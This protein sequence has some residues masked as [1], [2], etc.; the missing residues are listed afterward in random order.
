MGARDD[1]ALS[2]SLR[3][4]AASYAGAFALHYIWTIVPVQRGCKFALGPTH[5]TRVLPT[6]AEGA[7]LDLQNREASPLVCVE[8]SSPLDLHQSIAQSIPDIYTVPTCI[9]KGTPMTEILV[10]F[11]VVCVIEYEIEGQ[12]TGHADWKWRACASVLVQSCTFRALSRT[13]E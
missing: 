9:T 5:R 6:L 13:M 4:R 1:T 11:T 3:H 10:D 7:H 2:P 8:T 12:G